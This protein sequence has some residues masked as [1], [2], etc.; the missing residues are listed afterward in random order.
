MAREKASDIELMALVRA[1]AA[2]DAA[3]ALELLKAQ[4]ELAFARWMAAGATRQNARDYFLDEIGHYIYAGD[5]ALHVA[6]AAHNE[7]VVRA[8]IARGA[9]IRARNRLGAEPLHLAADGRPGSRSWN[10]P[11]QAATIALLTK[12][13]ADP[14]A[15]NKNGTAPLHRAIRTR[16]AA[17][18]EA[19][20]AGGA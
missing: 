1:I 16:S 4:P 19:L 5:T 14:N 3:P 6:A 9:D 12:A 18:V 2:G 17:A 15:T 7:A 11:A 10:P 13:G 20:L 8:L